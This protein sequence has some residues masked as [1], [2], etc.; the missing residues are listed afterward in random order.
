M[1]WGYA[2][3]EEMTLLYHEYLVM[4]MPMTHIHCMFVQIAHT[5]LAKN[6]QPVAVPQIDPSIGSG[7]GK[8]QS[9]GRMW[10]GAV[11]SHFY[12][13]YR[14]SRRG[15]AQIFPLTGCWVKC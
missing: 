4:N 2:Q 6:T 10:L 8:A 15:E 13:L 7:G 1:L 3:A 9:C 14:L 11:D 5:H 12:I